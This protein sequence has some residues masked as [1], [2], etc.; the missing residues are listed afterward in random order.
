MQPMLLD[1]PPI[2]CEVWF[3]HS[4]TYNF[5]PFCLKNL[6]NEVKY[7]CMNDVDVECGDNL[8]CYFVC[9]LLFDSL[10][11]YMLDIICSG[12]PWFCY[13]KWVL[14]QYLIRMHMEINF[15]IESHAFELNAARNK[16][17]KMKIK[18]NN[19]THSLSIHQRF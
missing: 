17:N 6:P 15:Q 9:L 14:N 1:S 11:V 8:K 3:L 18:Q 5:D 19:Q 4:F 10:F 2:K 13:G 7:H 12:S 16:S